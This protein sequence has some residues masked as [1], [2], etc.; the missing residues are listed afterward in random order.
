MA[1]TTYKEPNVYTAVKRITPTVART[2]VDMY[3]LVIGTG[4]ETMQ[5]ANVSFVVDDT[6]N[7]TFEENVTAIASVVTVDEWGEISTVESFT[8]TKDEETGFITGLT[9]ATETAGEETVDDGATSE[10]TSTNSPAK[11][12]TVYVSYTAGASDDRYTLKRWTDEDDISDFYGAEVDENGNSNN[13]CIGGR[14]A[15]MAGSPVVYTLQIPKPTVTPG[16]DEATALLLAYREALEENIVDKDGEPIWRINPVDP[17]V[18]KAIKKFVLDMSEPEER[19]EKYASINC[20][21]AETCT[22]YNGLLAAYEAFCAKNLTYR[23]QTFYPN[24]AKYTC[25]D[26]TEIDVGG[27]LIACA[28]AGFE[29]TMERRSQSTTHSEIPAGLLNLTGIKLKRAQKN[30]IASLGVTFLVQ[31]TA[32]GSIMVRD[33]LSLDRST[34]QVEDPCVT[35]AVDYYAKDLRYACAPYIGKYNIDVETISKVRGTIETT[36]AT[37]IQN[38]NL[39]AVSISSLEQDPDNLQS[40]IV[41]LSAGVLYPLKQIN[42]NIVLE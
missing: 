41:E 11:G 14:L 32:Y 6:G 2:P 1:Q 24:T 12:D 36:N 42:V 30:A 27:E 8:K 10:E 15:K 20:S 22:T 7:I 39:K 18:E 28:Y 19:A 17:G 35:M 34:A 31:D 40:L 37:H 16:V 13:I 33:A 4:A 3:P 29:Q 21:A 38:K 26:G 9:F 25:A 23:G 5:R